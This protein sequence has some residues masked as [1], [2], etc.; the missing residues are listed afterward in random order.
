[1]IRNIYHEATS[2]RSLYQAEREVVKGKGEKATV[3]RFEENLE[4]NLL[5]MSADLRNGKVPKV[6][7]KS[8][9]VYVP[10][11]RKVIYIDYPNKIIQRSIYDFIN[12]R[13]TKSFIRDTYA[14]IP[15]RGQL[16]AMKRVQ[17]WMADTRR[18][19]GDWYY[20]KFDVTKFFYRI[21]HEVLMNLLARRIDDPQ[22]LDLL[23]YYICDTGVPFGLPLCANQRDVAPEEM[24][25]EVGIPIGGGLSHTLGN[26]YLDPLDQF[27]KRELQVRRFARYM[28]DGIMLDNNKQRLQDNGKRAE[29]FLNE[30]LRLEFNS[31][32][33]IRPVRC[34]LEFVGCRIYDDHAMIRKST[35][36][37]MK[38]RLAL[39]E[40]LYNRGEIDA[41][42][43]MQTAASYSAMLEHVDMDRFKEK[44]WGDFVLTK[45][46]IAAAKEHP[47]NY[48]GQ[49]PR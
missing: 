46:S 39:V 14:C 16:A 34:G 33:I 49:E 35:T 40:Q 45:G 17:A 9:D 1:M 23:G 28:D 5:D 6:E 13:L 38:R 20:F 26:L 37:R 8:F 27:I 42:K 10:K 47:V 19:P 30:K 18:I 44:L 15:G 43:A 2:F 41:K 4:E 25:F 21:D 32:T 48:T 7:Y 29:E 31:K 22:M 11:F 12:P 36:L 3:L 24:L